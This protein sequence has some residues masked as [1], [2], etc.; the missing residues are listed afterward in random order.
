MWE[1]GV[2]AGL[3]HRGIEDQLGLSV[4]VLDGGVVF[5][6]Y[7]AEGLAVFRYTISK[8]AIVGGIGHGDEA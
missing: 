5:Y 7:A 4:F 8:H 6:G 2:H 1:Q 3:L